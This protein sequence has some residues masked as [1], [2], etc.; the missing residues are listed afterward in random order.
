M[1]HLAPLLGALGVECAIAITFVAILGVGLVRR[2]GF[3]ALSRS[4]FFIHDGGPGYSVGARSIGSGGY[5]G[6]TA[7]RVV[8]CCRREVAAL[9]H[10]ARLEFLVTMAPKGN[11]A[12]WACRDRE[13]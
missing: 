12:C 1:I 9:S 2:V 4:G 8:I 7:G 11:T 10:V 5:A 3:G 13:G 6:Q